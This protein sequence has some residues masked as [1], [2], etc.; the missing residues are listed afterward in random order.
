MNAL[1]L[2]LDQPPEPS[3][4]GVAEDSLIAAVQQCGDQAAIN[5]K[6]TVAERI[7]ARVNP[8]KPLIARP[9]SPSGSRLSR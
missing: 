5:G 2:G 7:D 8:V 4:R 6:S 1:R 3:C 9:A